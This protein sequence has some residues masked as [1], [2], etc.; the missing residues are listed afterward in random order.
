MQGF[1]LELRHTTR[2]Q[3]RRN[4]SSSTSTDHHPLT[5]PC[6]TSCSSGQRHN[7]RRP[8]PPC[9]QQPAGTS[10]GPPPRHP[11]A[12][13][14][15]TWG[16]HLPSA[17]EHG[18]HQR[19]PATA[20]AQTA[21]RPPRRSPHAPEPSPRSSAKAAS[22]RNGHGPPGP[23]QAQIGPA[24]PPPPTAA[25]PRRHRTTPAHCRRRRTA[26]PRPPLSASPTTPQPTAATPQ[27]NAARPATSKE[28][29][30]PPTP[31]GLCPA[32]RTGGGEGSRGGN[33]GGLP[34]NLGSARAA[35]RESDAGAQRCIPWIGLPFVWYLTS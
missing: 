33:G 14:D 23:G 27:L 5:H 12:P 9:L 28:A 3:R 31:H 7:I 22:A 35:P 34:A 17:P 10:P 32:T 24:P 18:Q 13:A 25:P 11:P 16:S 29:P 8:R 20:R 6:S 2:G 21:A 30:P 19:G 4:F 1:R 26:Q 15:S